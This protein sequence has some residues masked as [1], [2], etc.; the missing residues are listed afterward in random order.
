MA[1]ALVVCGGFVFAGGWAPRPQLVTYLLFALLPVDPAALTNMTAPGAPC[2]ALPLLMVVWVNAHGGYVIGIALVFLFTGAE[3]LGYWFGAARAPAQKQ[4]L[5]TL[6][7]GCRAPP[8][9]PAWSNPEFV[10]T[11]CTRSRC[12]A[13]RRT[14][15]SRNGRVRISMTSAPGSTCCCAACSCCRYLYATPKADLTELLIPGFFL[16][17]GFVSR[18]HVPLAVLTL[19]P[20]IALALGRGST[21]AW[22]A[23]WQGS[24]LGRRYARAARERQATGRRP[25]A[26]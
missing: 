6:D 23:R 14:S 2:V 1:F 17:I 7:P 19:M 8:C 13:W 24:R 25:K 15:R 21:A 4:R 5:V 9:W 16:L 26:Y 10:R 11:G 20:F 18:R 3:W 22:A 12:S